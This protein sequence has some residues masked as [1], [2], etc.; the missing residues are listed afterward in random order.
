MVALVITDLEAI[1]NTSTAVLVRALFQRRSIHG[2]NATF[3]PLLQIQLATAS[4]WRTHTSAHRTEGNAFAGTHGKAWLHQLHAIYALSRELGRDL[5][6][7]WYQQP[8][9][10]FLNDEGQVSLGYEGWRP[11]SVS[12]PAAKLAEKLRKRVRAVLT[13]GLVH[14]KLRIITSPSVEPVSGQRHQRRFTP[15]Q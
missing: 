1:L 7:I 8:L 15:N 10:C 6:R 2:V 5:W 12:T 14:Q 3:H 4:A 13:G 9:F 11:V